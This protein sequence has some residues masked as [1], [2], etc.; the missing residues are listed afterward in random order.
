LVTRPPNKGF[1]THLVRNVTKLFLSKLHEQRSK[2][3]LRFK[4]TLALF[5]PVL[6]HWVP[7][8]AATC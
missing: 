2:K 3:T 6:L 7:T 8:H 4:A 1:K 5:E